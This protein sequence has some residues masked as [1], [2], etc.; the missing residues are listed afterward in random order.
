MLDVILGPLGCKV[1]ALAAQMLAELSRRVNFIYRFLGADVGNQVHSDF[2][3][4]RNEVLH[5]PSKKCSAA[6]PKIFGL[7]KRR[8]FLLHVGSIH[9]IHGSHALT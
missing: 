2:Y 1:H 9:E 4:R 3:F 8:V 6:P 7:F 5:Y